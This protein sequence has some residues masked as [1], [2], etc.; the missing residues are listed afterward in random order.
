MKTDCRSQG[1]HMKTGS[2]SQGGQVK[3]G[4]RSPGGQIIIVQ[5]LARL[6]LFADHKLA[7]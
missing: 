1:G 3:N 6:K 2:R 7:S 4:C 5:K